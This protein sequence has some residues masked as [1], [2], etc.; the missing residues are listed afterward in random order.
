MDWH[1][2]H[3]VPAGYMQLMAQPGM[4]LNGKSKKESSQ[5][6]EL[7]NDPVLLYFVCSVRALRFEVPK[8]SA[9][10]KLIPTRW[11]QGALM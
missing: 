5:L 6:C 3:I 8:E 7:L 11:Y 4:W 2:F 10:H 9:K 1:L